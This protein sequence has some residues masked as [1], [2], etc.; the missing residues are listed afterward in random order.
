[1]QSLHWFSDYRSDMAIPTKNPT[2]KEVGFFNFGS[3]LPP[4]ESTSAPTDSES[5]RS[6]PPSPRDTSR[7]IRSSVL[8]VLWFS[9]TLDAGSPASRLP[10]KRRCPC[11]KSARTRTFSGSCPVHRSESG[12]T[13]SHHRVLVSRSMSAVIA[14]PAAVG[15]ARISLTPSTMSGKAFTYQFFRVQ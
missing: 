11:S 2:P 5:A 10:L 9:N 3:P 7:H 8:G 15:I 6:G 12:V 14:V 4:R 1:M 13:S